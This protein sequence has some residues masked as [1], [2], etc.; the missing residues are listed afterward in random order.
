MV[1]CA[2]RRYIVPTGWEDVWEHGMTPAIFKLEHL[3][4]RVLPAP[5]I[6]YSIAGTPTVPAN[7]LAYVHLR[8]IYRSTGV[9]LGRCF[10]TSISRLIPIHICHVE[11]GRKRPALL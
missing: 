9:G 4:H 10:E 2:S 1:G 5:S 8:K 6:A 7:I 3:H 11:R